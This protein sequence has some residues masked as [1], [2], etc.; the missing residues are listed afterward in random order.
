MKNRYFIL[1]V[2]FWVI[3]SVCM[4]ITLP[5]TPHYSSYSD[6]EYGN[7]EFSLSIGTSFLNYSTLGAYESG[8]CSAEGLV[9][10]DADQHCE[11]CCSEQYNNCKYS[12]G[13]GCLQLKKDCIS[14]CMG[15]SLPLGSPLL[16]LP[17]I[18]IYA[19]I[20]KRKENTMA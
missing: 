12:G 11:V 13:T 7:E 10:D 20:R 15:Y 9:G 4:A 18:A 14:D 1:S 16:L 6:T 19:V 3:A 8:T 17:F 2:L 5:T